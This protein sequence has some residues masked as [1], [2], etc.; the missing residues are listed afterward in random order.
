MAE[1]ECVCPPRTDGSVRHPE[2]DTVT[3]RTSLGFTSAITVRNVIALLAREEGFDD[4]DIL[5]ALTEKYLYLGIE[6]WTI[7]DAKGKPV[8]VTR[9]A[10]AEY[11]L[12]RPFVAKV[13][14]DEADELYTEAVVLPLLA[15]RSTSSPPTPTGVSTSARTP[16]PTP[17]RKRS[18]PS[19]TTTSRTDAIGKIS[20]LPG[21]G[22]NYSQS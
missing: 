7:E 15:R 1:I 10:I 20:A 6:S 19:S 2:G 16:S 18:R 12:S 13:V 4:T 11:L 21:G 22:S 8:P 5:A 17:L 3:L 9:G 14:G